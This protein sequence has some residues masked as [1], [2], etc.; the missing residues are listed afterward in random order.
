[1]RARLEP[2][3]RCEAG[4]LT[5]VCLSHAE[6]LANRATRGV[7]D[8]HQPA[9]EQAEADHAEFTVVFS[10]VFDLYSYS[11]EDSERVFKVQAALIECSFAL[12]WIVGDS[13]LDIVSTKTERHN[14]LVSGPRS[15][16]SAAAA[17]E[18]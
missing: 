5:V 18:T 13:R 2:K 16:L 11:C 12:G 14:R 6:D 7:A 8:Y 1:M 9:D 17:C 10:C 4:L 15:G 3:V